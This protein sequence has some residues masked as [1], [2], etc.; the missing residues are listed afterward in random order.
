MQQNSIRKQNPSNGWVYVL[1]NR[2]SIDQNLDRFEG[3]MEGKNIRIQCDVLKQYTDQFMRCLDEL[4]QFPQENIIHYQDFF[5]DPQT[6]HL[7]V[8]QE[9]VQQ[10]SYLN[11][12]LKHQQPDDVQKLKICEDVAKGIYYLH[13]LSY[14]HRNINPE[15]ICFVNGQYKIT[16]LNQVVHFIMKEKLDAVGDSSYWNQDLMLD[17]VYD[18]TIDIFAF[19]CVV[20][21]VYTSQR[22]FN[23]NHPDRTRIPQ[24]KVQEL[25]KLPNK[26]SQFIFKVIVEGK[27]ELETYIDELQ[28]DDLKNRKY[29]ASSIGNKQQQT[30]N[31]KTNPIVNFEQKEV[32][33]FNNLPPALTPFQT[34]NAQKRPST[35]LH[36]IPQTTQQF[37]QPNK[38]PM[39]AKPPD[40]FSAP[41]SAKIPDSFSVQLPPSQQQFQFQSTL[42]PIQQS[43]PFPMF[44]QQTSQDKQ[45]QGTLKPFGTIS[46]K[47]T[48][49]PIP[50][51]ELSSMTQN[52]N[53][54]IVQQSSQPFGQNVL[55][56]IFDTSQSLHKKNNSLS[57]PFYQENTYIQ[58][59]DPDEDIFKCQID[60]SKEER[61][62]ENQRQ[63][64]DISDISKLVR[65]EHQEKMVKEYLDLK[66]QNPNWTVCQILTEIIDKM[67][68]NKL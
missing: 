27:P 25:S 33:K 1:R 52:F 5:M 67:V 49:F 19:A 18:Q 28:K 46:N 55:P 58:K 4:I 6:K 62:K 26:L 40:T 24:D 8:I 3:E 66:K 57:K 9:Y 2:Q 31:M 50:N 41:I 20:F 35:V 29:E 45:N 59:T 47:F 60:T 34:M 37:I 51:N 53:Q 56:Q 21:E 23:R 7:Y 30:R 36:G 14:R 42:K 63:A 44:P 48:N 17:R 13:L 39:A 43:S 68:R 32:P 64:K 38:F 61:E 12:Q 65:P 10:E 22:L 15:N 16:N 11:Y 54:A